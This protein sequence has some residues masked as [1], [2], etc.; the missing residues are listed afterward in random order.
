MRIS[1][2]IISLNINF[3]NTLRLYPVQVVGTGENEVEMRIITFIN[4]LINQ[5]FNFSDQTKALKAILV[6]ERILKSKMSSIMFSKTKVK[7]FEEISTKATDL[8]NNIY[9]N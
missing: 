4:L 5:F 1:A 8:I 6:I 9:L 3:R 2:G 7:P